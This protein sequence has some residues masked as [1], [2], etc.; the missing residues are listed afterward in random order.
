V[1]LAAEWLEQLRP[2][3]DG[4]ASLAL[5]NI[6]RALPYA[7]TLAADGDPS[8][9]SAIEGAARRWYLADAGY[10]G[11]WEPS[12]HDFLSPALT[13]A[14]LLARLL[15]ADEFAVW[16]EAFLITPLRGQRLSPAI[17]DGKPP[18]PAE[19]LLAD[20]RARRVL[21]PLVLGRVDQPDHPL[22]QRRVMP[23]RN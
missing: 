13:E 20:L 15:P 18:V 17:G 14:E 3:A 8:L 12:A 23:G 5:E 16:L 1:D 22:D 4:Y 2:E 19:V 9:A 7:R 11:G 6:G 21:P 10:P